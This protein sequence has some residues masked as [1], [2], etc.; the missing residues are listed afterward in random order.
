[1]RSISRWFRNRIERLKKDQRG[2][3]MV[4]IIITLA[5]MGLLAS[6]AFSL[7][8]YLKYADVQ[9]AY[10][11]I[12]DQ[13]N[14]LQVDSMSKKSK[15]EIQIYKVGLNTYMKVGTSPMTLD[16]KGILL[17]NG[18]LT[19]KG[20]DAAGAEFAVTETT[21]IKIKYQRSGI[22]SAD[23]NVTKIIVSG[24]TSS[25]TWKLIKNTGKVKEE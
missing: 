9:K 21:P 15:Q 5:V 12:G 22:F 8:N 7:M 3:S 18:A 25:Y 4:E 17:G 19:I 11:T 14:K 16:D 1:M 20:V 2:F 13:I 24:K 23:T 6:S 10:K